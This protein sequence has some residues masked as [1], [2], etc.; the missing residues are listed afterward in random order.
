MS[1]GWRFLVLAA[2]GLLVGAAQAQPAGEDGWSFRAAPYLWAISFDGSVSHRQLPLAFRADSS[3][4]DAWK[5]LDVDKLGGMGAFEMGKGRHG[6][7]MDGLYARVSTTVH[8]PLMGAQLPAELKLQAGTGL[9]AYR[10]NWL[11]NEAG[12][13]GV[14][15]GARRWSVR[16]RIG[17]ASP[18]PLP[19]PIP[20]QYSSRQKVDWVDL[21]VGLKGRRSFASHAF[22]GGWALAGR[23]ESDLSTDV[24]LLAGYAFSDRMSIIAGYRWLS[25]DYTSSNGFSVD[26]TLHGPGLGLE[27]QF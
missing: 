2:P 4:G 26:T 20:Q 13:L 10:Y 7:L 17:Y 1:I 5:D 24:M 15:I 9:V 22:V 3:F 11:E 27:Y 16:T 25:S 23:G 18:V 14:V 19:P 6:I 8:A 21:Q 12:H